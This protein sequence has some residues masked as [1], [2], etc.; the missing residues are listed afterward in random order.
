MISRA[1]VS[2]SYETL[3]NSSWRIIAS[4]I[5]VLYVLCASLVVMMLLCA[6][7]FT[8]TIAFSVDKTGLCLFDDTHV[9]YLNAN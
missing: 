8:V 3:F 7:G 2:S 1:S 5:L 9:L 6:I 4:D